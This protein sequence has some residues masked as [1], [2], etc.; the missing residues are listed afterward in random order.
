MQIVTASRTV[1][2]MQFRYRPCESPGIRGRVFP[3][4]LRK[5]NAVNDWTNT[6]DFSLNFRAKQIQKN[7]GLPLNSAFRVSSSTERAVRDTARL[8]GES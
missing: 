1:A 7:L 8:L 5:N 6:D 2:N 4:I 3:C